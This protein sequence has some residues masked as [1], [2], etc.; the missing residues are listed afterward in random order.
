MQLSPCTGERNLQAIYHFISKADC[1]ADP[2]SPHPTPPA[3]PLP[4]DCAVVPPSKAAMDADLARRLWV[5]T[6]AL[7]AEALKV[8]TQKEPLMVKAQVPA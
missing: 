8:R 2:Y 4:P 3:P 5:R 1:I 7:I 6:E